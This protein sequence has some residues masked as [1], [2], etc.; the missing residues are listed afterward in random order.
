MLGAVQGQMKFKPC[1]GGFTGSTQPLLRAS[2][3]DGDP[4]GLCG[5]A[6]ALQAL[7]RRRCEGS[8]A[9]DALRTASCWH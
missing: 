9:G 7:E 6:S 8:G 4:Q 1:S 3:L 5:G 2:R